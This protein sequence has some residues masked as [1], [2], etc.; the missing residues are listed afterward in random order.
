[1]VKLLAHYN[2]SIQLIAPKGLSLPED[3]RQSLI[4]RGQLISESEELD[5]KLVARSDV[6]YCTRVQKER[7][8]N[9]DEYERLKDKLVIDHAVLRN[10][11]QKMIIM[12]PL[13]RN[14][15]I[16]EA[17][18]FDQRAAYFRQVSFIRLSYTSEILLIC[19]QMRYGLYCRMALLALVMAP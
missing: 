10:A 7:F 14:K 19:S 18:D 12:H 4:T 11:K 1:M 2:V 8:E 13:P 15:E 17:V 16:D 3:I 6:L 9:P 5:P